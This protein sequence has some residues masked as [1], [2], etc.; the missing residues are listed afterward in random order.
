[1][2]Y[3]YQEVYSGFQA[4]IDYLKDLIDWLFDQFFQVLHYIS[5]TILQQLDFSVDEI[6]E[7]YNKTLCSLKGEFSSLKSG[8]TDLPMLLWKTLPLC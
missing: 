6:E 3:I 2:Q 1:L 4:G 7:E 8:V 5:Y